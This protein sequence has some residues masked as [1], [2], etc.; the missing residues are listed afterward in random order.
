MDAKTEGGGALVIHFAAQIETV[1]VRRADGD[2]CDGFS[3]RLGHVFQR[4]GGNTGVGG[5]GA[6]VRPEGET[7]GA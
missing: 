6:C 2:V 7:L 3:E 5:G 4:G 1:H